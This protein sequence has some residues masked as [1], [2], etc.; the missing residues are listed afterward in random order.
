MFRMLSENRF[1]QY[2]GGFHVI[3][4][5]SEGDQKNKTQHWWPCGTA[6][7]T[8]KA[9]ALTLSA[10]CLLYAHALHVRKPCKGLQNNM[11]FL[12]F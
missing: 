11:C 12:S 10:V 1:A 4:L 9:Q 3:W 6:K 7:E 8:D 2:A 5:R